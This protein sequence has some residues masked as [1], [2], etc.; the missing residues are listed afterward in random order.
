MLHVFLTYLECV[1]GGLVFS[2]TVDLVYS[3]L[4]LLE[5]FVENSQLQGPQPLIYK[6]LH[7]LRMKIR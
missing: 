3:L 2:G 4:Q 7:N 1:N 6:L 5:M